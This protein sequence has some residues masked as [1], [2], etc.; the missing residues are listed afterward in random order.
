MP[1][2]SSLLVMLTMAT[3]TQTHDERKPV[4]FVG[5]RGESADA[6]ENTLAAFNLAWSRGVKAIEL[7]VHL[8]RDGVLVVTHDPTSSESPESS[9]RSRRPPGPS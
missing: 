5:H 4:E 6:P 8:T 9:A 7:D 3:T 2:L 1:L